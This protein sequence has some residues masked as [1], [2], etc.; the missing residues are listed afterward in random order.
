MN[1]LL[2]AVKKEIALTRESLTNVLEQ[3]K[4]RTRLKRRFNLSF[5]L[6]LMPKAF[7][8]VHAFVHVK[9]DEVAAM[10]YATM[11][12]ACGLI[13]RDKEEQVVLGYCDVY[14]NDKMA[15]APQSVIDAICAHECGHAFYMHDESETGRQFAYECEADLYAMQ[16]GYD[17]I[18]ALQWFIDQPTQLICRDEIRQRITAL[19]AHAGA[20]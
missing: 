11:P 6:R 2:T 3:A 10:G 15:A 16:H 1:K 5:T 8:P 20:V 14:L 19:Q 18:A 4:A 17:I 13:L 12:Y 9:N 7:G